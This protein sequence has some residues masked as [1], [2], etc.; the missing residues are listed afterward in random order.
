[1][2]AIKQLVKFSLTASRNEL[3]AIK[4]EARQQSR[5]AKLT[6]AKIAAGECVLVETRG[7]CSCQ[8]C[9]NYWEALGLVHEA[10][11]EQEAYTI[12]CKRF[13]PK[14]A[15]EYAASMEDLTGFPN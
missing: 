3:A 5:L 2:D 11:T 4:W 15:K 13:S 8:E 6:K 10:K 7:D 9:T 12:L 14:K 1:V